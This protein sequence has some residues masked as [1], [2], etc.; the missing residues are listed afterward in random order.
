MTD[1]PRRRYASGERSL[2]N[3]T[4]WPSTGPATPGQ[5]RVSRA[6]ASVAAVAR[7]PRSA[8]AMQSLIARR[9][10]CR[11]SGSG[12]LGS[13]DHS[14]ARARMILR[15]E[16]KLA[17]SCTVHRPTGFRKWLLASACSGCTR[18]RIRP[19][20]QPRIRSRCVGGWALAA[21]AAPFG[22]DPQPSAAPPR[23]RRPGQHA[24]VRRAAARGC[25]GPSA[26]LRS[27][28]RGRPH[29]LRCKATSESGRVTALDR[30]S[31]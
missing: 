10:R 19:P 17:R 1:A 15:A 29:P 24:A 5:G 8:V 9:G 30:G 2:R 12:C 11:G 16:Y 18:R 26:G 14:P 13:D 22:S 7:S 31:F 25:T 28:R 21:R 4:S 27:R 23:A 20:S 3:V 6:S